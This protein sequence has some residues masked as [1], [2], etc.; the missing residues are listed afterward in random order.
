MHPWHDVDPEF[1]GKF[2]FRAIVEIPKGDKNKYELDKETGL[3]KIDRILHS[4]VIYPANYG[5]IPQ[6][7]S[8]DGDPLDVLILAQLPIVPM[9]I[10]RCRAIGVMRMLDEGEEDDKIIAVHVNDPEYEYYHDIKQLPPHRMK[11]IGRFFQD[12][13][14]LEKEEVRV[15]KPQGPALA[16]RILRDNF[17]LYEKTFV[18]SQQPERSKKRPQPRSR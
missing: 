9:T 7:L 3:L 8:D 14:I 15:K 5:L 11:E 13:S 17:S 12:Y 10:V 2:L 18:N 16:S 4:S 6:S 1:D